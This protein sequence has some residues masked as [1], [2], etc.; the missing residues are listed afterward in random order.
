MSIYLY[1]VKSGFLLSDEPPPK[2]QKLHL[3]QHF[4]YD[5]LPEI[6]WKKYL[7]ASQFINFVRAQVP[8][9]TLHGKLAKCIMMENSPN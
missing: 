5:N 3:V 9:I 1:K 2:P 8:K 6:H 4:S 7:Y